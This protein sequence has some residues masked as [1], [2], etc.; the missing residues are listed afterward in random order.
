[1]TVREWSKNYE[2]HLNNPP[3]P[4]T[5]LTAFGGVAARLDLELTEGKPPFLYGR[6]Y[7]PSLVG[8]ELGWFLQPFDS[9]QSFGWKAIILPKSREECLR[10][11]GLENTRIAVVSLKVIRMSQSKNSILCEIHRHC[12][13]QPEV[14]PTA[15]ET[16]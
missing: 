10:R 11:V 4:G 16:E 3:G 9:D 12:E 1:M 2:T 8:H 15:P 6:A 5:I 7:V 13:S 14:P